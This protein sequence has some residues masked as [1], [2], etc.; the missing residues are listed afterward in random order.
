MRTEAKCIVVIVAGLLLGCERPPPRTGDVH[1]TVQALVRTPIAF[2]Q[3]V[4]QSPSALPAPKPY[5]L[6]VQKNESS[7]RIKDLAPAGDYILTADAMDKDNTIVA[8]GCAAAVTVVAGQ[9]A[10]VIIYLTSIAAPPPRRNSSPIIDA[11]ALSTGQV[12]AGGLI[13]LAGTA[14]DPDPGQTA[15]LSFSW[16]P[17]PACGEVTAVDMLP[18]TDADHPSAS[19]AIYVAPAAEKRCDITL[20]VTDVLGL[21]TSTTFTVNVVEG[22][23]HPEAGPVPDDGGVDGVE[24]PADAG[25]GDAATDA[26]DDGADDVA[27]DVLPDGP[28]D[29]PAH[30]ATDAPDVA[31]DAG[32]DGLAMDTGMDVG[33]EVG[34]D[35]GIDGGMEAGIDGG[36]DGGIDSGTDARFIAYVEVTVSGPA[37]AAPITFPLVR[38]SP[39]DGKTWVAI[40]SDLPVGSNYVFVMRAYDE[41]HT[42][43]TEGVASNVPIE[44]G[45][46]TV[47]MILGFSLQLSGGGTPSG[48]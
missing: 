5:Y 43:V 24:Q 26:M 32:L 13:Y 9:T 37:L 19:S 21:S 39:G 17:A 31:G 3:L 7:V 35:G 2:V 40:L 6:V 30:V 8:H 15:T 45:K 48:P 16:K 29:A 12:P 42:L 33:G 36:L 20:T 46:T 44:R 23:D 4:L 27:V 38:Q 1:V 22:P 18:G 25:G 47:I 11:I 41:N 34:I 28:A 14:H 10:E